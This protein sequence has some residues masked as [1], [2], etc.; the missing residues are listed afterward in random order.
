M[1]A[2]ERA[3]EDGWYKTGDLMRRDADGFYF[4]VG[5]VDDMFNCGGE[6]VYP[7]EVESLL[8]RHPGIQQA[9]VVPVDDHIKGQIPVA[10]VV[11]AAGGSVEESDVKKFALENGPAYQHP[12][13]VLF[14]DDLPLAGSKKIDKAALRKGAA[15]LAG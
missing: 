4:F 8:E 10:F 9:A 2:T 1:D 11:R 15:N 3:V 14:V 13:H 5:R 7:G 12:R 6:N